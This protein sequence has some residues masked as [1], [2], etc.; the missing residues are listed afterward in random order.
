[1]ELDGRFDAQYGWA[2]TQPA[3]MPAVAGESIDLITAIATYS[4]RGL[5]DWRRFP[6]PAVPDPYARV[7]LESEFTRPTMTATQTRGYHHLQLTPTA[8]A[9]LT[10]TPRLKVRAGAGAQSEL[11]APDGAGR[12]QAVIEAGATLDPT[13]IA[14]W[15][16][17]AVRLEGLINYDFVDP[18]DTR[19]HQLRGTAKLSVPLVPTLFLT[20]GLDVF[21]AQRQELG[22]GASYD[23]TIGL[24]LHTDVARQPL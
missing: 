7:W 8:G 11:L 13:A 22:W 5:R 23:T 16:A 24:R 4:Y 18:T 20:V 10:L 3:G 21:G 14:T 2:R 12:W 15:G 19:Q 6:K 17:L 9:Q 1:H